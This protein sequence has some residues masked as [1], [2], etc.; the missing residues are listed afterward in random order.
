M[1]IYY[2]YIY[3]FYKRTTATAFEAIISLGDNKVK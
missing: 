3:G 2:N 1:Y